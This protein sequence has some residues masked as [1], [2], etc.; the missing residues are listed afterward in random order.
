MERLLSEIVERL[1]KA[2]GP[3]LLSVILYGSAASNTTTDLYSDYNVLCVLQDI[4]PAELAVSEPII[5]WWREHGNPSPL[6]LS[7]EEI[8]NATDC[9]P[10]EF[11]DIR[12]QRRVLFGEDLIRDITIDD[13]Y[14]RAM[15]EHELRSKL[16]RLRQK[17]GG[18]L[19]DRQLL[20][21]LMAES[22]STFCVLLRHALVL[23]GG[24]AI[25]DKHEIVRAARDK[26]GLDEV[27]FVKLLDLR[28]GKIRH[29][30]IQPAPLFKDY[31]MQIQN[32]VSRVDQI[33]R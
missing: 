18:V 2:H 24:E 16:L 25:Y 22:V 3:Q 9:F 30:E 4:T 17:A 10:M 12:A 21:E 23:D 28:E 29:S 33:R 32:V 26:F 31:L 15:V 27:P 11:Y 6:F 20:L 13:R 19:S 1:K 14:Y 5:R 7:A 8:R